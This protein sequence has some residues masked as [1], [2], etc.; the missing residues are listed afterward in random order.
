MDN[1]D[2]IDCPSELENEVVVEDEI[3][4]TE[5]TDNQKVDEV[6]EYKNQLYDTPDGSMSGV[7]WDLKDPSGIAVSPYVKAPL[8]AKLE[9]QY[10][11]DKQDHL[12]IHTDWRAKYED[13]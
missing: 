13:S 9:E 7:I 3:M 2:H 6:T 8:L 5:N 1:H 12:R 11:D 4:K 10:G